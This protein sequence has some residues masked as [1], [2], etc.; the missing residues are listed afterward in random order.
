MSRE[1]EPPT[2]A[3]H[4]TSAPQSAPRQH[5]EV[6]P[7]DA[8]GHGR[9]R[10]ELASDTAEPYQAPGDPTLQRGTRR[11]A[12]DAPAMTTWWHH[13]PPA[14]GARPRRQRLRV[15]TGVGATGRSGTGNGVDHHRFHDGGGFGAQSQP[16][17]AQTGQNTSTG[18]RVTLGGLF[19]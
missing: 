3:E 15:A 16:G 19:T 10:R 5:R 4:P 14:P 11:P 8:P 17:Q 9:S 13:E 2:P 18:P 7:A 6:A 1:E 12:A